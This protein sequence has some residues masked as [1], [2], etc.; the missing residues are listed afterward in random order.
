[1]APNTLAPATAATTER[2]LS[3]AERIWQSTDQ[4][5]HA[6]VQEAMQLQRNKGEAATPL[7]AIELARA[8]QTKRMRDAD[9]NE[10]TTSQRAAE[11]NALLILGIPAAARTQERM[12][13][14]RSHDRALD[15]GS[16]S[17]FN[18]DLTSA[19]IAAP[20]NM[21][22]E[23]TNQIRRRSESLLYRK[24][25]LPVLSEVQFNR[26]TS[27]LEREVAVF[28]ALEETTPEGW[29]VRQGSMQE[30]AL[31][32]D[33]VVVDNKGAE[34]R[35]DSKTR[36]AFDHVVDDLETGHWISAQDAQRGRDT[37]YVYSPGRTPSGEKVY[38][39]I[40]DADNLGS[41]KDFSYDNP[42]KVLEFV[43]QQFESQGQTRLR[44]LGRHAITQ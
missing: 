21:R 41:I 22:P 25:G 1:M 5:V 30:D 16:L 9:Q 23:F 6:R 40:F 10:W 28:D 36:Y 44:K 39:C 18:R 35:L 11:S 4:L 14:H 20:K 8:L 19:I 29:Q 43:E 12:D 37:G 42:Y 34:L 26:I 38:T 33:I 27:G 31:G 17:R 32:T 3:A 13:R 2:R 24:W 7:S 15:V